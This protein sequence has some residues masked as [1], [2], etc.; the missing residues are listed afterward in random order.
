MS[1]SYYDILEVSKNVKNEEIKKAYRKLALQWHPDK[2][3]GNQEKATNKFKQ[4]SEAYEVL[5]DESKRKTYDKKQDCGGEICLSNTLIYRP[6]AP[7]IFVFRDPNDVFKDFFGQSDPFQ[8][9]MDPLYHIIM[10]H[11]NNRLPKSKYP[12]TAR[13]SSGCSCSNRITREIKSFRHSGCTPLSSTSIMVDGKSGASSMSILGGFK[14]FRRGGGGGQGNNI[15]LNGL[16]SRRHDV[17]MSMCADDTSSLCRNST[18][19]KFENGK[20]TKTITRF[21]NGVETVKVCA[22]D[23]LKSHTVNG[24]LRK[25][26]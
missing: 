5:S 8:E 15:A 26:S 23:I 10:H 16:V 18:S 13:M 3:S 25:H 21:D 4:I 12:T 20:K 11:L 22:N 17:T 24:H 19:I 2:N 14:H 7:Q 1:L 6:F 9:R